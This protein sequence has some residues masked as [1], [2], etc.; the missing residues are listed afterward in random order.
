MKWVVLFLLKIKKEDEF[1]LK[2]FMLLMLLQL[3]AVNPFITVQLEGVNTVDQGLTQLNKAFPDWRSNYEL[4]EF[5][6]SEMSAFVYEYLKACG[7]NPELKTGYNFKSGYCHAWL[8]CGGSIVECTGL[9]IPQGRDLQWYA[10]FTPVTLSGDTSK[11][12]DWWNSKY[13]IDKS[14]H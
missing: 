9:Y 6:C 3:S 12:F 5:D 2:V 10:D 1:I 7:L 4:D 8:I 11:E 13:I 14:K